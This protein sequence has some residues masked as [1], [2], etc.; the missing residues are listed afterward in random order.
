[1]HRYKKWSTAAV[2][3]AAILISRPGV[4]APSLTSIQDILYK[5][6]GTRFNGTVTIA[7]SNFQGGDGTA[8]ATQ[9][10]TVQ[11]VNG[12]FRVQL[13]PTTSSPGAN[14]TAVYSSQGKYQFT[15]TWA[16]PQSTTTLRIR[17][18]RVGTGTVIG[19]PGASTTVLIS[20]VTGLSSELA[21]RVSK[22]ASFGANRAAVVNSSGLLDTA[23][24]TATDCLHV[25]G[26][27]GPCGGNSTTTPTITTF[28][29][30]ET[31]TGLVDGANTGFRLTLTP[32]PAAS[33]EI[34]RNGLRMRQGVDYSLSG[35]A[36]AFIS[37][38]VPQPGDVLMA[39][40]RTGDA[41]SPFSSLAFAQVVCSSSGTS[42]VSATL[43]RLGSC[44][45]PVAFLN[46]GDRFEILA[47]FTHSGQA[48]SYTA[49]VSWGN[50]SVVST[51][52]P[53]AE[54]RLSVHATIALTALGAYWT[55][56]I[57]RLSPEVA[58]G[59]AS[60]SLL[61]GITIGF[62]GSSSSGDAVMLPNF[63]VI[64]Y[65]AQSNP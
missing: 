46:A 48:A 62:S 61:T 30:N 16:V 18:I 43:T 2:I 32:S 11:V 26:S 56:E 36:V 50:T 40:Y 19:S 21:L 39:S 63:T 14:Y 41:T 24:G 9:S 47:D 12:I 45:I 35:T 65:P 10:L 57:K 54:A 51:T 4:S 25:D 29:D 28:I 44:T 20:D 37:D 38:A 53:S 31:P 8:V 3:A 27:S 52:G 33:L 42:T 58:T 7:W 49:S 23:S 17:D 55:S 15:E 34:Y 1:M 64:R 13:V 60:D 5:A 59:V 22:G 6:D